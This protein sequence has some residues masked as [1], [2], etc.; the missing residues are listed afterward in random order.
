MGSGEAA[1][2]RAAEGVRRGIS[3]R[4]L[5]WGLVL[6]V[7]VCAIVSYAEL[8]LIHIQIGFLQM[9]PAVIGIFFFLVLV[10]NGLRALGRRLGLNPT[11]LLMIYCMMVIAA[12]VSSRGVMEKVLPLLVTPNYYSNQ[13]NRWHEL[14]DAHIKKWMVAYD[15]AGPPQQ[16]VAVRFFERLWSGE[17]IPWQAWVV[18]LA[19]W[20]VLVLLV[21]FV[22]LCLASILRK[23]WVDNEKLP[24]PLVQ[25]PLELARG[26]AGQP[27]LKSALLWGGVALPAVVFTVNG[28]HNMFPSVP[29]ITLSIFLNPYIVVPPWNEVYWFGIF[30][31]FAAVGFF[32]L[33]P[34]ELLFSLWFF[35]LF[36]RFQDVVAGSFG[37]DIKSMPVYG[38][39]MFVAY[40]TAGAYFVL[41]GYLFWVARPHL[42]R[43]F[44]GAFSRGPADDG[45]ELLPCRVAVWGLFGGLAL[46]IGWCVMAGMSVWVAMLQFLVFVFIIAIVMARSTAEAGMLMTETSFRPMDLYR[47]FG[48]SAGLGPA[49]LTMLGFM[50]A[51][52]LRDQR[53]LLLTGFLDGLKISD[54]T[55]APRKSFRRVFVVA[56]VSALLVAG[57]IQLWLPY[58]Q[59]GMSLYSYAYNGNNY[60]SMKNIENQ[61]IENLPPVVEGRL[62]FLVGVAVTL[63]LSYLRAAFYWWPLHPL[64]Y[65]LCISWTMTVFWFPCL[66]AWLLKTAIIRYGGMRLYIKARPWFL[67]MV[68]GEFG[69]A[70]I[71]AL[72]AGVTGSVPPEFPWP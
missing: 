37:F 50:D 47:M 27:L 30:L 18:P 34:S 1:A 26:S 23:Q 45:Q 72:V 56:V 35:A 61:M 39:H 19:A 17:S 6:V 58:T 8:V 38:T 21:I 55:E 25:L 65:A 4:A 29:N 3:A 24:F 60:W 11:E 2:E 9:P 10:N 31:S 62:W 69:M 7:S 32:F 44:A 15:P 36:A 5:A 41:A 70:V 59:G 49:N 22:F 14:F 57:A 42:K 66:I 40:Q 46:I 28:L 54:G 52:F 71:W 16:K 53:G 13:S 64:G 67:G 63:A 12:M 33:L 48:T 43:V 51:A 68:L 20:G